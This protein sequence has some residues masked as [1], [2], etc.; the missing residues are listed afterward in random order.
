M[1]KKASKT[2]K[3]TQKPRHDALSRSSD[4]I[5]THAGWRIWRFDDNNI[6][7]LHEKETLKQIRYYS[8]L[9]GALRGL[10]KQ[11]GFV[12]TD[13]NDAVER[14]DNLNKAITRAGI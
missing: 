14:I 8:T 12:C 2:T 13:L 9:G 7:L 5:F 1:K 6:A 11:I 10:V 3:A 4:A